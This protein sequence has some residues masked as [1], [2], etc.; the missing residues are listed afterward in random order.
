VARISISDLLPAALSDLP[1]GAEPILRP[2]EPAAT[3]A[4]AAALCQ[5]RWPDELVDRIAARANG[6]P[7]AAREAMAA[8][9]DSGELIWTEESCT[10]RIHRRAPDAQPP[11]F[12]LAKRVRLLRPRARELLEVL[13]L[14]GGRATLVEL[15]QALDERDLPTRELQ[16]LIGELES[17]HFL[18]RTPHDVLL[19]S[20]TLRD[21][22][23]Q[24]LD[25]E[26]RATGH[27]ELARLLEATGRPL[28]LASAALHALLGGE[29]EQALVLA[30]R[31]ALAAGS[32]GLVAT[33]SALSQFAAR[34]ERGIL[35][36]RGLC[37][38]FTWESPPSLRPPP[39]DAEE[40]DE[41]ELLEDSEEPEPPTQPV[42]RS[43]P[44]PPRARQPAPPSSASNSVKPSQPPSMVA[45]L[46]TGRKDS[47]PSRAAVAA[48]ALKDRD[49]EG[50]ERMVEELRADPENALAA[51]RLEAMAE[52]S[53]GETA[54]A[55]RLLRQVKDRA[56]G[57][58]ASTRSRAA[59]ALGVALA[60]AG[61]TSE[62]LLEA[63]EALARA[64]ES[65]DF[66]GERA[67]ATFLA[68]LSDQAGHLDAAG[69]WASL[70]QPDA[71]TADV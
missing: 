47:E 51:D 30:R 44:P 5:E 34:T 49:W 10:A 67:C 48:Q 40:V 60:S 15:S 50:V 9:L 37:G 56:L 23:L 71:V 54:R 53:R 57:A 26:R 62:A 43:P 42:V 4:L 7:L 16:T 41:V 52:L 70:A 8:A 65:H 27:K 6:C 59:L 33:A 69:E 55:L 24:S 45:A 36:R 31:A 14:L 20:R 19:S 1:R 18:R 17:R 64:R 68:Q 3:R 13:A 35:A 28:S 38:P 2:F 32:V 63:L 25:E 11:G 29:R 61:R 46:R 39:P 58:D 22:L 21:V 66:S 12:W